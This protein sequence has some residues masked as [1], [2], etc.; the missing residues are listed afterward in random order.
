MS[1]A[2]WVSRK[3]LLDSGATHPLRPASPQELAMAD[4]VKVR[5][6]GDGQQEMS[7]SD[8]GTILVGETSQVIVPMGRVIQQLGYSVKWTPESCVLVSAEREELKLTGNEGM[9]GIGR[10]PGPEVDHKVGGDT[11][12]GTPWPNYF[13]GKSGQSGENEL[14]GSS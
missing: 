3:G 11:A 9:P 7:Q 8:Q 4:K 12:P 14:L 13:Y 6:A 5:L 1:I 10:G 2:P